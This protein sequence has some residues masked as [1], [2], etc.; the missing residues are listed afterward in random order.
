MQM[1]TK[2]E[3]V[4]TKASIERIKV[5]RDKEGKLSVTKTKE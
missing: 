3:E 1:D 4:Q 5:E 2:R